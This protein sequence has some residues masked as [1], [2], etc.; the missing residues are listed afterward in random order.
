MAIL[1]RF[2]AILLYSDLAAEFLAIRDL[3]FCAAKIQIDYR[4]TDR[5][6]GKEKKHINTNRFAGLSRDWVGCKILFRCFFGGGQAIPSYY[7]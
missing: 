6:P 4:Q 2:S 1:N 7:G 5:H 3:R